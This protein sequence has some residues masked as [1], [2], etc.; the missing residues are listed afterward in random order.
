ML[1]KKLHKICDG[2]QSTM[3]SCA[4]Y[5]IFGIF[6]KSRYRQICC[7][8]SASI[9][10]SLYIPTGS[11][12]S[13]P[14]WLMNPSFRLNDKHWL[15]CFL[16]RLSLSCKISGRFLHGWPLSKQ[17]SF[18]IHGVTCCQIVWFFRN[19]SGRSS[20]RMVAFVRP[21]HCHLIPKMMLTHSAGRLRLA[22]NLFSLISLIRIDDTLLDRSSELRLHVFGDAARVFPSCSHLC[23]KWYHSLFWWV[24]CLFARVLKSM[25]DVYISWSNNHLRRIA[26]VCSLPL[27]IPYLG[28][29]YI[30]VSRLYQYQ[31]YV[32]QSIVADATLT[33][34]KFFGWSR[35]CARCA[36]KGAFIQLLNNQS[37]DAFQIFHH[38][39]VEMY[40]NFIT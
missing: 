5:A 25:L 22:C 20:K 31:K 34:W 7:S 28:A 6:P 27:Y 15:L 8:Q 3:P 36:L 26:R 10:A 13:L 11:L 30:I 1:K 33:R 21:C 18:R 24:C 29:E 40:E 39:C 19:Q 12:S 32:V 2:I 23:R 37:I 35:H 9:S 4:E 38:A 17:H 14:Q 16:A